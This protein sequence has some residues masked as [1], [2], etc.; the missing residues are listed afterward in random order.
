MAMLNSMR[1]RVLFTYFKSLEMAKKPITLEKQELAS[2]IWEDLV[3]FGTFVKGDIGL[4]LE[5]GLEVVIDHAIDEYME[6]G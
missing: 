6:K 4:L 1:D 5:A 2:Q 3:D